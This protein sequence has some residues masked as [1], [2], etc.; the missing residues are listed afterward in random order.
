M[1]GILAV[2]KQQPENTL[3]MKRCVED[4]EGRVAA[5]RA[6]AEATKPPR[7]ASDKA[8]SVAS[9]S[10]A[11]KGPSGPVRSSSVPASPAEKEARYQATMRRMPPGPRSA[12]PSLAG[13][14][15][16]RIREISDAA[17]AQ[18]T[19]LAEQFRTAPRDRHAVEQGLAKL[20]TILD[21]FKEPAEIPE[22]TTPRP[23]SAR[24]VEH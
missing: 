20:K 15:E 13:Q 2:W 8:E 17:R 16:Y 21:R 24:A 18:L 7:S 19:K 22:P 11:T 12:V 10:A 6:G 9:A 23:K 5:V 4:L 3:A 14:P 1:D